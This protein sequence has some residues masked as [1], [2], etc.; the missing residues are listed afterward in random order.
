M[1]YKRWSRINT[2]RFSNG[3]RRKRKFLGRS[4]GMLPLEIFLILTPYTLFSLVSESFRQ[5][6]GQ[7]H[8]PHADESLQIGKSKL[9]SR[10]TWKFLYY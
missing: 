5:D 10:L 4:R 2:D 8:S 1:R 7:L 3:E 6:I 9:F